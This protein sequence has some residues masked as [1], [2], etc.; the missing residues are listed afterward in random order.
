VIASSLAAKVQGKIDGI[1]V[2]DMTIRV[3]VT[4]FMIIVQVKNT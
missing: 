4:L 3:V 2:I 1:F